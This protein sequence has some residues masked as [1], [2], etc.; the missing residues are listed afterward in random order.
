[1]N[2]RTATTVDI[3]R[4]CE[5][6]GYLFSQEAEFSPNQDLQTVG[7]RRIIE[8]PQI[9]CILVLED[10][11]EIIGMTNLLFTISTALGGRVAILEDMV[12]DPR[13]RRQG[14][15]SELLRGTIDYARSSGCQRITLLTD[16]INKTAQHFYIKH[17][18]SSSE[19]MPMRLML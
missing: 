18:F 11:G 2:V 13:R 8:D 4:L 15:G 17:G 12:I 1:M 19:M 9:G 6:L 14:I 5:L 7:L 3:P 10:V 16:G